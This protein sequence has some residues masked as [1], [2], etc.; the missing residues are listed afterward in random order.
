MSLQAAR[1]V[2]SLLNRSIVLAFAR[3]SKQAIL[4]LSP[5]LLVRILSVG[6]YGSY[7]EFMLYGAIIASLVAFAAQRSLPYLIP[8]YPEQE[9]TWIT[10]TALFILASSSVAVVVIYLVGDMIRANTSFDFV[11]ALQLY[12]FFFINLDFLEDY[13]LA[14]KRTDYVLYYSS[15]RLL[16]RMVVVVAAAMLT[17]DAHS[18]ALSLVVLEAARCFLVLWYASSR[19]WFSSDITRASLSL[20]MSYF[21]PLGAGGIIEQLN[22]KAGMLFISVMLGAEAL[23]FFAIGA[24][25]TQIVNI[26]RGAVSDVIFP[27]IVEIKSAAPKDA[28]PLWER[29]T[30]V[31]CVMLFPVAI[32]FSY[33]ADAIVTVMFTAEYA[34]AVPVFSVLALLIYLYCFDFHLPLRVQNANRYFVV[35]SL[36]ALVAN[37]GLMYPMYLLFGLVGPAVALI[38]SRLLLT[39]YLG[40]KSSRLYKVDLKL[41]VRWQVIGKIFLTSLMCS[42]VLVAGKYLVDQYWLRGILFGGAYLVTYL[43]ALRILGIWDA[44]P[45]LQRIVGFSTGRT[46]R[47][48]R[49]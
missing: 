21:V 15:G 35:G 28:L 48:K 9:R 46:R 40:V 19:R 44:W 27:E 20:Q 10:Q 43:L 31:F 37:L 24:F 1:P 12:I 42:P 26:L 7:R 39:I 6:E 29:A 34:A 38:L 41:M 13:W 25:A 3:F 30:V 33:Y 16:A 47:F 14:R 8:K 11:I 32:L 18:I 4:L 5:V 17:H 49:V 36:V 23:A 2:P 22:R 45:M